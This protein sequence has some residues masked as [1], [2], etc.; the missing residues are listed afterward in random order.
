M[1]R[2]LFVVLIVLICLGLFMALYEPAPKVSP[3]P[4]VGI[5]F[6]TDTPSNLHVYNNTIYDH[7]VPVKKKKVTAPRYPTAIFCEPLLGPCWY[8]D[9]AQMKVG[10]YGLKPYEWADVIV[11][12]E[13]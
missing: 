8:N 10:K 4:P 3:L 2:K 1:N 9:K 7:R 11:G 12:D 6:E 13:P 5:A